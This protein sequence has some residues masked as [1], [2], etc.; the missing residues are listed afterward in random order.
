MASG[1]LGP[2]KKALVPRQGTIQEENSF[3]PVSF[4]IAIDN[5]H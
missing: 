4:A 3:H 1:L 5:C 2:P